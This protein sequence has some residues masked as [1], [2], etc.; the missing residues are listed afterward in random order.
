MPFLLKAGF[1]GQKAA[2]EGAISTILEDAA[3]FLEFVG[4]RI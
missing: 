4:Q 1:V 3:Q 2:G